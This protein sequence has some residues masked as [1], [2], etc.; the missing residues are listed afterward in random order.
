MDQDQ[1]E[2]N[3]KKI[4]EELAKETEREVAKPEKVKPIRHKREEYEKKQAE[5]VVIEGKDDEDEGKKLNE[6]TE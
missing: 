6:E 2:V 5:K 3:F 1:Q 4:I